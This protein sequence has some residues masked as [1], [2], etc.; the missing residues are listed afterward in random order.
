MRPSASAS[1]PRPRRPPPGLLGPS[2]FHVWRGSRIPYPTSVSGLGTGAPPRS[3]G[4]R[5]DGGAGDGREVKG[6]AACRKEQ[7]VQGRPAAR[8][9]VT[10]SRAPHLGPGRCPVSA[11]AGRQ[12]RQG[13]AGRTGLCDRGVVSVPLLRAACWRWS[14]QWS[15][16]TRIFMARRRGSS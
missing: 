5:R 16:G 1:R 8:A 14:A 2:P 4:G 10:K 7:Q 6:A 9:G 3:S 13:A 15:P 12:Q 11:P